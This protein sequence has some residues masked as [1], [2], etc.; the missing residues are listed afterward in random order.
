MIQEKLKT[1]DPGIHGLN[2]TDGKVWLSPGLQGRIFC[3]IDDELMHK[4]DFNMAANP[5]DGFNNIGGNSLWPGPEGGAFAY[6]Y[7]HGEWTV[8]DGINK[9]CPVLTV[10]S[11]AA[12]VMV[13]NISL[14]NAKGVNVELEYRRR[15]QTLD[16]SGQT[17]AFGVKGVAYTETDSFTPLREYEVDDA[18]VCAWSLEQFNGAEGIVAF[19]SYARKDAPVKQVVNDDFYG[20]PLT[21]ITSGNGLFRFQ[22]G[23]PGRLQIG[24]KKD[25][26]PEL[27][28]AYDAAHDMLIIR[29]TSIADDT[30]INIAD[31]DQ[32]NGVYSTEDVYSIFN[33]SQELNFF[34]LET[35]A[36]MTVRDGKLIRSVLNSRTFIYRGSREALRTLL[37]KEYKLNSKEIV[38]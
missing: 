36:P 16:I 19:G 10:E 34:E 22:L 4:L 33:G 26:G 27:I 3:S 20:D 37:E 11:A 6:N 31:N 29:K 12:A 8:Q 9:D 1:V 17:A 7:P 15:V 28:G 14:L 21:R 32:K 2:S 18:V 38:K 13:K 5:S 35:I 23:G 30:Y 24:F 25:C